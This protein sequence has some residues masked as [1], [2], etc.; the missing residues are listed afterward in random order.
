MLSVRATI[1]L[2]A[3]WAAPRECGGPTDVAIIT[4][5]EE[6]HFQQRKDL[7][8]EPDRGR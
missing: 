5:A 6:T 1:E 8:V 2:Q 7:H 4:R 3:L